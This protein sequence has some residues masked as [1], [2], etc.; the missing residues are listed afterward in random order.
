M[1]PSERV[2]ATW[3]RSGSGVEHIS[4]GIQIPRLSFEPRSSPPDSDRSASKSMLSR[5]AVQQ[6][7][8]SPLRSIE[9]AP[10][11]HNQMSHIA[12]HLYDIIHGFPAFSLRLG[13]VVYQSG[14]S[15]AA[16]LDDLLSGRT[17]M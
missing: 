17:S 10:P 15:R 7:H 13:D 14:G 9:P 16:Q 1:T 5:R 8:L 3:Y 2:E 4:V 12:S 11:V 6:D